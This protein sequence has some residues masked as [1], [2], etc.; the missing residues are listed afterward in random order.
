MAAGVPVVTA[1]VG[2]IPD[3]GQHALKLVA[4]GSPGGLADGLNQVLRDT[5]Y[6][7]TLVA[8]GLALVRDRF[9][10]ADMCA[11]YRELYDQFA[12]VSPRI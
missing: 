9:S 1:A 7:R 4:P 11:R 6:R 2:G 5:A 10:S 8:N 12:G 3:L